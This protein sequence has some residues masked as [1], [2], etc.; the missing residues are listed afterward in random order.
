MGGHGK[1][2]YDAIAEMNAKPNPMMKLMFPGYPWHA[3]DCGDIDL[4]GYRKPQSYYRDMVWNG[5]DRV[6]ATVR[7]PEPEGKKILCD[8]VGGVSDAAELDVA[9]AGRQGDAGGGVCGH[10]EGAA[11]PERQAGGGDGDGGGQ[12]RRLCSRCPMRRGC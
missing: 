1:N 2:R 3:A 6:Y 12:E 8:R 7:L 10:G 5:G 4:T 9:G 11:L